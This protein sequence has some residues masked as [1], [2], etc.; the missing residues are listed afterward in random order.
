MQIRLW[1]GVVSAV[2]HGGSQPPK[3]SR[4]HEKKVECTTRTSECDDGH[5]VL[6][7]LCIFILTYVT[8]ARD[9]VHDRHVDILRV[10]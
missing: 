7:V 3:P 10:R 2:A 1:R 5:L 9:T 4:L 6:D 8:R